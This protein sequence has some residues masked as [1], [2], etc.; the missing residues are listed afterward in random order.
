MPTTMPMPSSTQG[1]AGLRG[2]RLEDLPI[3]IGFVLVA[4]IT[5][6]AWWLLDQ[7]VTQTL[8]SRSVPG[9]GSAGA[10]GVCLLQSSGRKK[11]RCAGPTD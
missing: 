3:L 9:A 6:A 2:R 5:A 11:G 10:P 8:V 4:V 1:R 7:M